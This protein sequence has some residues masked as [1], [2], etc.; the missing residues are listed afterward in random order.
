[1]S[2]NE[3]FNC[4]LLIADLAG[5]TALTEAHGHHSAASIVKKFVTIVEES[6]PTESTLVQ[7]VGDEVFIISSS[8]ISLLNTAIEIRRR[9]EKEAHF[10]RIH[11]GLHYGTLIEENGHYFGSALNLTSRIAGHADGGQILCSEAFI[12]NCTLSHLYQFNNLGE[13]RFKNVKA[14]VKVYELAIDLPETTYV[15]IDP[16]CHMQV[17]AENSQAHLI[18]KNKELHFCSK[19]CERQFLEDPEHYI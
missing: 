9:T 13:V 15:F 16:V 2:D 18:I 14:P 4:Y 19:D 8:G 5:Y 11:A 6:I 12:E 7:R 17:K 10:P 3:E 1:M